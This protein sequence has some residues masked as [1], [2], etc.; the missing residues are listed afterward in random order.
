ML[1]DEILESPIINMPPNYSHVFKQ[2]LRAAVKFDMAPDF[3]AAADTLAMDY[4]TI[5]HAIPFCR[6]PFKSMWIEV[7]ASTRPRF[8]VAGIHLPGLQT[9]PKRVGFLIDAVDE[10]L[11]S[12]KAH[13]FWS[14]H[15]T[16]KPPNVSELAMLFKPEKASTSPEWI[17][18]A[19]KEHR[20]LKIE[21]SPMWRESSNETKAMLTS[22]I[23]AIPPDWPASW[24]AIAKKSASYAQ[25]AYEINV[26]DWSGEPVFLLAALALLNTV[27]AHEREQVVHTKL[28][29]A[30][31]KSGKTPLQDYYTLKIHTRLK[32]RFAGD[33]SGHYKELRGHLV[34]GHWKVR[35]TGIYFWKP[36]IRGDRKNMIHKTYQLTE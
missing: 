30:R 20:I 29:K 28:N 3:A 11:S 2:R 4:G 24:E 32:E 12:F 1:I 7:A 22:V 23:G 34:R 35:K 17:D 21:T 15:D 27:N 14:F 9:I 19:E 5:A 10:K 18:K 36:F 33:G 25:L 31:V 6:L 13:Q 16:E 26:A 8:H